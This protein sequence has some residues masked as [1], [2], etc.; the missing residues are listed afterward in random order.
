MRY[1]HP[2]RVS[3]ALCTYN[4]AA[5]LEEQLAS[6]SVQTLLPFEVIICD[7][8]S[9]DNT[10]SIVEN[11]AKQSQFPVH[12]FRNQWR[13]GSTLNFDRAIGLC[14]GDIIALADQDDVWRTDKLER[15]GHALAAQGV[16]AV[17]SD[18]EVTDDELIPLGYT[19]WQRLAFSG[20]EQARVAS[21]HALDILL[22]RY[23]VM[24][25]TLVFD[26]DLRRLI[27]P[28]PPGWH[29]DAWI[30]L[31]ASVAGDL[32][33]DDEALVKYR[34]HSTNQIGGRKLPF[35]SQFRSALKV[36]RNAYLAE[37]I[38]RWSELHERLFDLSEMRMSG[39]QAK[40][41]HLKKRASFPQ[42]RW[43][44]FFSVLR[45]IQ[46]GGYSRYARNWGSIALDLLI[47]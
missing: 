10:S 46:S 6:L 23:V 27:L 13:L 44:R 34:Q 38:K 16:I 39:I 20:K 35:F 17:F 15:L 36:D 24:G 12:F 42:S 29:H 31:V 4:G 18:A 3:V 40:L 43:V 25:A 9:T 7:D 28:I 30:A 45:E 26:A 11:F 33:L 19:M 37:E 8:L 21:G 1:L 47:K 2:P 41:I 14:S 22:K 32:V 5:F